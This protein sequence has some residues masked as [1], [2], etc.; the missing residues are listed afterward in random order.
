[1]MHHAQI[2]QRAFN[3][4]L[5]VD[6]AKALAFLSGLG[7]RIT[8]QEITFQGLEVD[9]SDQATATLPAR[10]SLFGNDLAQRHQRNGS[11]PFAVVDG[12]AVIEIAA[13]RDIRRIAE[14][15]IRS[16][17]TALEQLARAV[18]VLPTHRSVDR[19]PVQREPDERRMSAGG[20]K[21]VDLVA[22]FF[23][24]L[25]HIPFHEAQACRVFVV[26]VDPRE[27]RVAATTRENAS[28]CR[29]LILVFE[30]VV[31]R[32]AV[33]RHAHCA[34]RRFG[35]ARVVDRIERDAEGF[36]RHQDAV[37]VVAAVRP[38]VVLAELEGLQTSAGRRVPTVSDIEAEDRRRVV[39]HA[40]AGDH[41]LVV[42]AVL[43]DRDRVLHVGAVD[44]ES[45]WSAVGQLP[46][47]IRD[48]EPRALL[49]GALG[50]EESLRR[51]GRRQRHIDVRIGAGAGKRI[52]RRENP[53]SFG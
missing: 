22:L 35:G 1:M 8:G 53:R 11:Q 23:F 44:R 24:R 45:G 38:R 25:P 13:R 31:D 5:M 47:V 33:D 27:L 14:G 18:G 48:V 6:P 50:A 42:R 9:A 19:P 4:P 37:R 43:G 10:A 26:M 7:P 51:V 32:Q 29:R 34:E 2:A 12:I 15:V 17:V 40:V 36:G 30:R 21:R 16:G 39:G 3:T 46:F 41:D 49:V 28:R 20:D 52:S